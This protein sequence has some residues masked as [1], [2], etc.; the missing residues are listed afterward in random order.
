MQF[1]IANI[2]KD[3]D[4]LLK[5]KEDSKEFVLNHKNEEEYKILYNLYK[6]SKLD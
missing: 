2:K 6:D 4:L 5:A 1:R 3:Y